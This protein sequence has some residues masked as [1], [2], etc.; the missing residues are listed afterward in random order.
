MRVLTTAYGPP[1][2]G[3]NGTGV[4]ATGIDLRPARALY[5][6]AVDPKLIPLHSKVTVWPNPFGISAVFQAE[7]TGSAIKG[8]HIDFYDWRGRKSQLGWGT[9]YADLDLVT[10]HAPA[11]KPTGGN[12]GPG[13]FPHAPPNEQAPTAGT[14]TAYDYSSIVRSVRIN[15]QRH[16]AYLRDAADA[17]RNLTR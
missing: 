4:T 8:A 9:R 12:H 10:A 7:D 17:I 16:G 13:A 2:T 5:I 1:W 11:T 6:I 15:L 3:I 14:D